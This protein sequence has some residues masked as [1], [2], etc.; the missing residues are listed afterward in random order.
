[1]DDPS[2]EWDKARFDEASP[3]LC[4]L[5]LETGTGVAPRHDVIAKHR[6][7]VCRGLPAQV[8][9]KLGP[10]LK[11]CGYNIKKDVHFLPIRRAA[12]WAADPWL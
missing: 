2:V 12:P 4:A 10:F 6:P 5:T 7:L 3:L 8:E 11:S 1:M 9:T